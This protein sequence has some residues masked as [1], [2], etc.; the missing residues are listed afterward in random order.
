MEIRVGDADLRDAARRRGQRS[1]TGRTRDRSGRSARSS[2]TAGRSSSRRPRRSSSSCQ[3][4][5]GADSPAFLGNIAATR[6]EDRGT[7]AF[8]ASCKR[9]VDHYYLGAAGPLQASKQSGGARCRYSPRARGRPVR[10]GA[11][12]L[13]SALP[14]RPR[15]SRRRAHPVRQRPGPGPGAR[16][17]DR[18]RRQGEPLAGGPSP[19][20]SSCRPSGFSC[21]GSLIAP[22]KVLT[23]APLRPRAKA[24]QLRI[25]AA[26]AGAGASAVP[27][28]TSVSRSRSAPG[29]QPRAWTCATSPCSP[30]AAPPTPR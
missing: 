17:L 22:T 1:H 11:R 15:S 5:L 8:K 18:R 14:P 13:P 3:R 2:P 24:G 27:G 4:L 26:A 19:S 28:P 25:R 16:A 20:R 10:A 9:Y 7:L 6:L 12:L 30:C 21:T 29:L 23:A